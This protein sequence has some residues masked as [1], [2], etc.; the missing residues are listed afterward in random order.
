METYYT[1]TIYDTTDRQ[2]VCG[3]I[4]VDAEEAQYKANEILAILHKKNY[5]SVIERIES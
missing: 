1:W 2:F 3:G 4:G 5:K